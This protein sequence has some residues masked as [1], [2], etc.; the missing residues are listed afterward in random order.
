MWL[1]TIAIFSPAWL[2]A[3]TLTADTTLSSEGYFV[4]NWEL[5]TPATNLAL[6]QSQTPDFKKPLSRSINAI[7]SITITGLRDGDYY[8]RLV[9]DT[10]PST[11]PLLVRV[12]HHSLER[13][14]LVFGLGL[15]LFTTLVATILIGK[16]GRE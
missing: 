3:N 16:R 7:G 13:A 11:Q 15:L 14:G 5:S 8:F 10:E 4:L 2:S 9:N 1:L 6:Q 12:Q